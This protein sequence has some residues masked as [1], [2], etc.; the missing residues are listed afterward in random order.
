MSRLVDETAGAFVS[1]APVNRQQEEDDLQKA[2]NESLNESGV[3]SPQP[4]LNPPPL[5]P[6]LQ[7]S[8]ITTNGQQFGPANRQDYDPNEWAMVQMKHY[9]PDPDPTLRTRSEGIPVFLR[10]RQ[11][12]NW[13]QHCIGGVLTVLH[14]IPAARN[15][16]LRLGEEP[17]Y[18][19]GSDHE[20]WKGKSI[21]PPD[22]QRARDIA[23]AEGSSTDHFVPP[24]CDELHRLIAFLDSTDRSYGT[25]DILAASRAPGIEDS[26][27]SVRDFFDCFSKTREA[28]NGAGP[29]RILTSM[30]TVHGVDEDPGNSQLFT[31]LDTTLTRET[32]SGL[33]SLYDVYDTILF[34]DLDETSSTAV[35]EE[36]AEAITFRFT[37][38]EGF[39]QPIDIPET[40]YV[41][42]YLKE[43]YDKIKQIRQD[44]KN[45]QAGFRK[46]F[47]MERSLTQWVNP[48][49]DGPPLDR[50]ALIK[51]ALEQCQSWIRRIKNK[52]FWE[53][54]KMIPDENVFYLPEH[55]GQPT[56][57]QRDWELI[58]YYEGKI[59]QMEKT[60]AEIESALNDTI[61]PE[62]EA[63]RKLNLEVRKLFKGLAPEQNW[64]PTHEYTLRG[65]V[66]D[67]NKVFVK[68]RESDLME[69]D[70]AAP[71]AEQW[72][73]LWTMKD[74]DNAVMSQVCFSHA[75][76][77]THIN[78]FTNYLAGGN[79]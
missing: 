44:L 31:I 62:R 46:S 6:P 22:M 1:T 76:W 59:R 20:W 8:G 74:N 79:L 38:P 71:P 72:I 18:G 16:L 33:E 24:W 40:F 78:F 17:P 42:R 28:L 9:E 2:I 25:A 12:D 3:Q 64:Y 26:S 29:D 54:H 60:L 65:V 69:M 56:L 27:D 39:E 52:A 67:M 13:R 61:L 55:E 58:Q 21:L 32:L 41:D 19:Y 4:P 77:R 47:E 43:N 23:T 49:K 48:I 14:S 63:L 10:C 57:N 35:I 53:D 36:A 7:E 68:K 11:D 50:R 37:D 70:D 73:K 66:C 34:P 75:I 5:P 51:T 45:I 30:A 15:I